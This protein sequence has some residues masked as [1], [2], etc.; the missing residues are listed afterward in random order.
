HIIQ[1]SNRPITDTR[2]LYPKSQHN[3]RKSSQIINLTNRTFGLD[4]GECYI[5]TIRLYDKFQLQNR[6]FNIIIT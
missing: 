4:I 6:D 5:L 3:E 2:N 1:P